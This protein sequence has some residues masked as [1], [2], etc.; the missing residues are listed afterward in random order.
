MFRLGGIEQ[1]YAW[2]TTDVIPGLLGREPDGEPFAEYW[3][4][5]HPFGDS[6]IEPGG[7]LSA[8][9][10]ERPGE[11]LGDATAASFGGRLPYLVKFLSAASPL[12]L[13]A[14]PSRSQAEQGYARE[15]LQGVPTNSP[16]RSF[17]DDW[18]KPET[19]IAL[20]PF[21]GLL[22]FREPTKTAQL[23]EALGVGD[24]LASVIG[25][26]RERT[27]TPALQE[28]F[29]DVL[30]LG[31]RRHLVDEVLGAAVGLLDAPGELGL[32]AK[33]AVELDEHFPGDPG[34]LAALLLNRFALEP[35]Q[36][37]SL[38]A[39]VMHAY[40]KG[41]GVEVMANSDNVLRGG[42]TRKH[43]DVDALLQ[44]VKFEPT[45]VKLLSAD[46]VD[47]LYL[48][49]STVEE[50]EVWLVQPITQG[51]AVEVPRPDSGRILV[52]AD[53][54]FTLEGDDEPLHLRCG[55]AVFV[56]AGEQVHAS[57]Q[58]QLFTVASGV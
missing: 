36:A 19:I 7:T 33:T 5:A 45:E 28:V 44:V 29:L 30:S 9:L 17:K 25:P 38:E 20:T 8:H 32:F 27:T 11:L 14:H 49:P 51:R 10:A 50:F 15:S 35:G 3:F 58:G 24:T 55:E 53:G 39:G 54:S 21:E 56:P 34:I 40:L 6:P 46:G 26:L 57:G 43:I 2:G 4:G 23:F 31:E 18:P 37:V 47:G 42:L 52:V 16:E 22:G 13:Q 1:H 48:F 12:S 41:T